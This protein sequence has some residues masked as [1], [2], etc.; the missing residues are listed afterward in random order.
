MLKKQNKVWFNRGR[1]PVVG[2]FTYA[3]EEAFHK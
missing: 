3:S 2:L 1:Y